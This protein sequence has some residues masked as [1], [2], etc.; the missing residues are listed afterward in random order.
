MKITSFIFT[1][2]IGTYQ[3]AQ[4]PL[5]FV[6][7]GS[8]P[9]YCRTTGYQSGNGI[10]WAAVTGGTPDYTYLWTELNSGN[11]SPLSTWAGLNPGLYQ[12]IVTDSQGAILIDT[13]EVDS[14]NP[15]ASFNVTGGE[16]DAENNQFEVVVPTELQLTNTSQP[17]LF[18]PWPAEASSRWYSSVDGWGDSLT[19]QQ[20]K[21]YSVWYEAAGN[22]EICLVYW[23]KNN[24]V[25]TACYKICARF[26][27]SQFIDQEQVFAYPDLEQQELVVYN[28][29][30][31]DYFVNVYDSS[32]KLVFEIDLCCGI[33]KRILTVSN[34]I[35]ICHFFNKTTGEV[36]KVEKYLF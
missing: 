3:F 6:E 21:Y 20:S 25:D 10:I 30:G 4:T 22:E 23:N 31:M 34:G 28:L 9:A 11:N 7:L 35:Y 8:E 17:D 33:H 1:T 15:E 5:H 16:F 12:I 2:L 24:C 26:S 13:V 36:V 18:E 14:V 29:T 32:G 19:F 27:E